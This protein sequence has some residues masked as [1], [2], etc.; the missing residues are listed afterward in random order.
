MV[1]TVNF[2]S[3]AQ[4]L[5]LL[6]DKI[7]NAQICEI[8]TFVVKDWLD[9][10]RLITMNIKEKFKSN[11][12]I[13]RSSSSKEDNFENSGAGVYMSVGNIDISD[14]KE[15][16][17][18]IDLVIESYAKKHEKDEY[19]YFEVLVQNMI[20]DVASSGVL[21]TRDFNGSPY[22]IVNFDKVTGRTDSVTNGKGIHIE[23]IYIINNIDFY[24][25]PLDDV[26]KKLI[27][28]SKEIEK[29]FDYKYL[30]IEWAIDKDDNLY[31]FQVRPLLVEILPE[32]IENIIFRKIDEIKRYVDKKVKQREQGIFGSQTL[33]SDMTDWNPA[34]LIGI[35]PSPLAYSLYSHIVT[36]EVWREGRGLLGYY[37]PP[38]TK[39]MYEFGGHPYIDVR[40]DFNS[41]LPDMIDSDIK[42]KLVNY[43]ID[44]LKKNP[45]LHDKVEFEIVFSCYTFDFDEKSKGL[46]KNGFS[47]LE[48]EN[49]KKALITFT[50]N[51]IKDKFFIFKEMEKRVSLLKKSSIDDL[52]LINTLD[53]PGEILN[54]LNKCIY[55]GTI[56]FTVFV[57]GAFI[58]SA[59]LK[60]LKNLDVISE[61][62]YENFM[63]TIDTIASD[64]LK[65]LSRYQL[66]ELNIQEFINRYGHLRPGTFD[67]NIPTYKE[68]LNKLIPIN[69]KE[70]KFEKLEKKNSITRFDLGS[71]TNCRINQLLEKNNF[72]FTSVHLLEFIRKTMYMR[73]SIKFEFTKYVSKSMELILELGRRLGI[74]KS[75]LGYL[76]IDD[77]VAVSSDIH[78]TDS[79]RNFLLSKIEKNSSI[80]DVN[81]K[82]LLPDFIANGNDITIVKSKLSKPNFI[83]RKKIVGKV[84]DL[85]KQYEKGQ[86]NLDNKIILIENADPGYDWI[87]AHNFS[88]LITK[89]GG[90]AS[91]MAIRCAEF[92]IPAVI[93]CGE[94]IFNKIYND[95]VVFIDCKNNIIEV[96]DD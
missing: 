93:G 51:I 39:L 76:T 6:K 91:H 59:L 46:K 64:F 3:K 26:F 68:S 40:R 69:K 35:N 78:S 41:Y 45:E 67:I 55:Y 90:T 92:G 44:K 86:V 50:D 38:G 80:C 75:Q 17:R 77:I 94:Q 33:F 43:Y 15:V 10:K 24:E 7:K 62:E 85:R 22:Y 31:I 1:T 27:T 28:T 34:E 96:I 5:I 52:R 54:L 12:I 89:Y 8:Y 81:S 49:I 42:E 2:K 16:R 53:I 63:K 48:I 87:F 84:L 79:M 18:A 73:E 37:N 70:S 56:P 71:D 83:T 65:D 60:S 82:I 36:N 74:D 66:N 32:N 72:S 21:F 4:T 14:E 57:R 11:K 9:N 61:N 47:E 58:G 88:G 23:S 19:I 20:E 30:D 95:S 29:I 13:V 25:N